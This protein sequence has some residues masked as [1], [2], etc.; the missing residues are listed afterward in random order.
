[1]LFRL[2]QIGKLWHCCGR[3]LE[4]CYEK[5]YCDRATPNKARSQN[6]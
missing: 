1:V 2:P 3:L 6:P 4:F 5:K